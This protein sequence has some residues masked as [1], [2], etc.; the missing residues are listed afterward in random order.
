ML[1]RFEAPVHAHIDRSG[2]K[3]ARMELEFPPDWRVLRDLRSF[4]NRLVISVIESN[5]LAARVSMVVTE[6]AENA[7]KYAQTNSTVVRL[8]VEPTETG[9]RCETENQ[10]SPDHISQLK[11]TLDLVNEGD[12]LE[13]YARALVGVSEHDTSS[14][15]G[16]A[17][18]RH[19]GQMDVRCVVQN[20]TVRMIAEMARAA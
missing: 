19:E 4:V 3:A 5:D 20:S 6:L 12:P 8:R 9:V 1:V 10:A 16:L 14:R 13:A 15:I 2:N 7:V 18:I 11:E 17:R